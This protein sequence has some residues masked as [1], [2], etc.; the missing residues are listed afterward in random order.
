MKLLLVIIAS[1]AYSAVSALEPTQPV[2][3]PA[4]E[5]REVNKQ[6]FDAKLASCNIKE[7]VSVSGVTGSVLTILDEPTL[8]AGQLKCLEKNGIRAGVYDCLLETCVRR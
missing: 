7:T 5:A 2:R 6:E 1:S 4:Q 3:T 8:E